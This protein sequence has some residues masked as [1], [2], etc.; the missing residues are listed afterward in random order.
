MGLF[1]MMVNDAI[2]TSQRNRTARERAKQ[3]PATT[4]LAA[5]R[6]AEREQKA[7]EELARRGI[8]L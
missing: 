1:H 7:R 8:R 5:I 6:K 4:K 2:R 3:Y